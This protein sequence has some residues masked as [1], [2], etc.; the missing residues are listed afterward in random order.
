MF[1]LQQDLHCDTTEIDLCSLSLQQDSDDD[2]VS[3]Q[4]ASNEQQQTV[5]GYVALI[6]RPNV[7]KSTLLNRL[8]G[9]KISI[10]SRKPQ[11]TRHKIL[12]IKTQGN[13]QVVYVDTPGLHKM[14]S[15]QKSALNR[16]MNRA[17]YQSMKEVDVVVFVVE[18]TVWREEDEW[19]LHK[20]SHLT[21]PIILAINKADQVVPKER[22]LPYIEEVSKKMQFATILPISAR[23]GTNL[24][25]L[26]SVIEKMLPANPF[27]YLSDQVTD[28]SEQLRAA[29]IIR[30]KL[31]KTL[32]QELPYQSLV[33]IEKFHYDEKLLRINA[34]IL[35][36][37]P[38]QKVIVIG[39]GGNRLKHIGSLARQ[40]LEK[41]FGQKV[42]L[43][44][45]V[46]VKSQWTNDE[47]VVKNYYNKT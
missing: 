30:E 3:N 8:M 21:C 46:K 37:R 42:F 38:G 7:G 2:F 22:L 23:K 35:V 45:W 40:E 11:T 16:Y 44:L 5:C 1:F 15:G 4:D 6:G 41:I 28:Q 27:F 24:R 39:K 34:V 32:G 25:Q 10:T 13:T 20:I 17:A 12:G 18:G 31:V 9:Q 19:I 29:E 36:E 26:E 33:L 14:D 47:R 43:G